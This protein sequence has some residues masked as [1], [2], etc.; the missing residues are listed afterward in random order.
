VS[1]FNRFLLRMKEGQ[2]D[3]IDTVTFPRVITCRCT[4]FIVFD[5]VVGIIYLC[6]ELHDL[7]QMLFNHYF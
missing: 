7:V 3:W 6:Y 1:F 4:C 2:G 5:A